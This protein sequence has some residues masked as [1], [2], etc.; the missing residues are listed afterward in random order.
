MQ[1]I[2]T[3]VR[4]LNRPSLLVQAARFGVDHFRPSRDLAQ[5]IPGGESDRAGAVLMALLEAERE[6]NHDRLAKDPLYSL[7]HHIDLLTAIMVT[8]RDFAR[9]A[10]P[11]AAT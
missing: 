3:Q 11:A 10:Q 2:Q 9:A 7:V 6:A 8:A 4:Q 1:E 5:L